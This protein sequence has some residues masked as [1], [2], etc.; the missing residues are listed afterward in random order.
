MSNKEGLTRHNAQLTKQSNSIS[1]EIPSLNKAQVKI[2]DIFTNQPPI[3]EISSN[4]ELAPLIDVIGKWRFYLGIKEEPSKQEMIINT[5][6]VRENFGALRIGDIHEAINLSVAG[7]LDCDNEAYNNFSPLYIGRILNAY[8]EY[9][10]QIIGQ[11]KRQITL[12]QSKKATQISAEE[13][14]QLWRTSFLS[15]WNVV[16][17]GGFFEDYGHS[18]YDYLKK[19]KLVT[20]TPELTQNALDYAKKRILEEKPNAKSLRD[21]INEVHTARVDEEELKKRYARFFV[22]NFWLQNIEK[23]EEYVHQIKIEDQ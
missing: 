15:A 13:K 20:N 5:N 10:N 17:Q 14:N 6:F 16:K 1:L 11:V 9:R 3:R 21:F 8:N 12:E 4:D 23:G 2:Y 18:W 19:N 7:K 22:V